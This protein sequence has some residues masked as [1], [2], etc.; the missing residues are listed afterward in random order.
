MTNKKK[1]FVSRAPKT[2][3][4]V[5]EEVIPGKFQ[6]YQLYAY[7]KIPLLGRRIR[8]EFVE[9]FAVSVDDAFTRLYSEYYE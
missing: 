6:V 3:L 8:G 1:R 2:A 5:V 7:M 4:N 9:D